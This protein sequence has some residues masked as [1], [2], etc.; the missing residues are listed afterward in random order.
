MMKKDIFGLSNTTSFGGNYYTLVIMDDYS[1][2]NMT[3]FLCHKKDMFA[4]FQKLPKVVQKE[5]TLRHYI[6]PE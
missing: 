2:Y 1:P 5:K 3:L 6:Y 4:L